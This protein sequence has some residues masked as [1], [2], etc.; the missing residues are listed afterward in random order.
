MPLLI[1]ILVFT[2]LTATI[3]FFGYHIYSRPGRVLERLQDQELGL[4]TVAI[5]GRAPG[6]G[7]VVAG[8]GSFL[9]DFV[10]QIGEKIPSSPAEASV[11]RKYLMAAG[12]R[13]DAGPAV[14]SGCR[15]LAAAALVILGLLFAGKL[16]SNQTLRMLLIGAAGFAGW[17][18]PGMVLDRLVAMRQERIKFALPDAIDLMVV[19]AEAGI[20]LDQA[21]LNVARDLLST[22]KD[23]CDEI[24]LVTL[25]TR[26]GTR[27]EDALHH[28]VERCQEPELKKLV[29]VLI[30]SE[31]FGTG[32]GE[33]LRTHADYLR[34]RRRQEAE[35]RAAKVGVKLVFPIFFCIMP[36][37]MIVT[38]GPGVLQV[39]KTLIPLLNSVH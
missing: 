9:V 8:Q 38:G 6:H 31:R 22:H 11:S 10:Q 1:A 37:M 20:G 30:Q 19:C 26:A 33:A 24:S 15:V 14:L 3:C 13:S 29:A 39:F 36:S 25:E 21:F 23:L 17:S 4:S 2:V 27:R 12:F 5:P 7:T 35:E 34:I 32:I 16:P 18:L 28:L